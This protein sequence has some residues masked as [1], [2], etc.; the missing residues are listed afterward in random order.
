VKPELDY[1]KGTRR[2]KLTKMF[3]IVH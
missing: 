2:W 3:I 1:E